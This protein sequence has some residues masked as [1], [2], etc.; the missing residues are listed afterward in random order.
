MRL[1]RISETWEYH[2]AV[3]ADVLSRLVLP[4]G[5]Q[6]DAIDVPQLSVEEFANLVAQASGGPVGR[7]VVHDREPEEPQALEEF[8]VALP[9]GHILRGPTS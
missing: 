9:T 1:Y 4:E 8:Q 3:S 6:F 5:E 2:S 7:F